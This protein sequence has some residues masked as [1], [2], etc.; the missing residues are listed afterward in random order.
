MPVGESIL[1]N[2]TSRQLCCLLLIVLF[3]APSAGAEDMQ[4]DYYGVVS[5]SSDANM[6]KMAQDVFFTQLKSMDGIRVDDKRPDIAKASTIVPEFI[7]SDSR[8]SFYAVITEDTNDSGMTV[9]KCRFTAITHP[10]RIEHSKTETYESY[11]KILSG[12]KNAIESVLN[13]IR[14]PAPQ[15]EEKAKVPP[16]SDF[17]ASAN[18]ES[19]AGTWSG[20]PY[21]DKIIIL[22]GGRGFII[23]KNGATMNI[24]ISVSSNTSPDGDQTQLEIAQ[25]GR[26]NASFYP[27]LPREQ[28]IEC[29][30]A[31]QPIKWNFTLTSADT[32]EG[33]KT[34]AVLTAAG[35]ELGT[36]RAVWTRK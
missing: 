31:G 35:I 20:E 3:F 13:D 10:D 26:P 4:V 8:V 11:Y 30:A 34:T 6:L 33:T 27:E 29:A 21:T 18:K 14:T 9:W 1:M 32:L 19:L 22:R 7:Q 5:E 16:A 24:H 36:T 17:S 25:V 15:F 12:A 23:F 28:A 2:R